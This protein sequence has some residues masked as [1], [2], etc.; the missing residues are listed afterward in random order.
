MKTFKNPISGE[1]I[2]LAKI[3]FPEKMNYPD[4]V[5]ACKQLGKGWRLPSKYE[6]EII[7][8]ELIENTESNFEKQA[9]WINGS[10]YSYPDRAYTYS[11]ENP[12]LHTR[13]N[14]KVIQ[15][16]IIEECKVRAVKVIRQD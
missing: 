1:T 15:E 9:Y 2:Q 7:F 16:S 13:E 11:F 12:T 14:P 6:W 3:D 5:K 4:A 10:F 8:K